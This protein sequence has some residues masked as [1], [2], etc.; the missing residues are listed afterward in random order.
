MIHFIPK[1]KFTYQHPVGLKDNEAFKYIED[2]V[3]WLKNKGED[4]NDF[5]FVTSVNDDT[6][7]LVLLDANGNVIE[8]E[9]PKTLHIN[10]TCTE[11]NIE[12]A[13]EEI[14]NLI[15]NDVEEYEGDHF[16]FELEKV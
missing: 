6:D 14:K 4:L 11:N 8:E 9:L 3:S 7:G 16:S 2:C 13:F 12:D 10:I 5:I 1:T 15:K